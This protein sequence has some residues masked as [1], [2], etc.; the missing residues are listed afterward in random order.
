L[1]DS[2]QPEL[3]LGEMAELECLL[4][5]QQQRDAGFNGERLARNLARYEAVKEC[6]RTGMG[7]RA[8]AR[9]MKMSPNT[10]YAVMKREGLNSE[11]ERKLLSGKHYQVASMSSELVA[12]ALPRLHIDSA[13]DAQAIGLLSAIATSKVM[14][15]SQD[16]GAIGDDNHGPSIADVKKMLG[17]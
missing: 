9:A 4:T 12:E 8:I 13:K 16:S 2:L 14:E 11:M 17:G 5:E 1:S 6:V 10:I 7:I 15:L 3:A